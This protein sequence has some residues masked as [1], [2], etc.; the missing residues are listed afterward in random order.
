[1]GFNDTY[2][3]PGAVLRPVP[4]LFADCRP[5]VV[6]IGM[7]RA[8]HT[9][10]VWGGLRYCVSHARYWSIV[11]AYMRAY[12]RPPLRFFRPI[13]QPHSVRGTETRDACKITQ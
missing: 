1:M 6:V 3:L 9:I 10:P 7:L 2:M 11:C 12:E 4:C 13:T 5:V 8:T